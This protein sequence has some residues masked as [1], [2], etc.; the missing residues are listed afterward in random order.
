M[1]NPTARQRI[2]IFIYNVVLFIVHLIIILIIIFW[3][4][5]FVEG[6]NQ[7]ESNQIKSKHICKARGIGLDIDGPIQHDYESFLNKH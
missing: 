3:L 2:Y 4:A 6:L 7:I 1:A 5:S